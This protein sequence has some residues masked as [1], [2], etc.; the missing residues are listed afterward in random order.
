MRRY[1]INKTSALG[2]IAQSLCVAQYLKAKMGPCT[3]DWI[4][5]EPGAKLVARHP[6]VDSVLTISTRRW[7]STL[8]RSATFREFKEALR[9]LR[10]HRYDAIFD[11]QGNFKSGMINLLARAKVKVGFSFAQVR[12]S[13]NAL[14][15]NQRHCCEIL[16]IPLR[17]L[18]LVRAHFGDVETFTPRPIYLAVDS[19]EKEL[20]HTWALDASAHEQFR[21]ILICPFSAWPSKQIDK[22]ELGALV[23]ILSMRFK[24]SIWVASGS[25]SEWGL[26]RHIAEL[27]SGK[28]RA[29]PRLQLP[30]FQ[31]LMRQCSCLIGLDSLALHLAASADVPTFGI[32]GPTHPRGYAPSFSTYGAKFSTHFWKACTRYP[33]GQLR[34]RS[35][36]KCHGS[37]LPTLRRGEGLAA[38][39]D[40]IETVNDARVVEPCSRNSISSGG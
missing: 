5:E 19:E 11:L 16:P 2:D 34:C 23:E 26:A 39:C 7:R 13:L 8:W 9:H 10:L 18:Q 15:T 36:R 14:T 25:D 38:L 29:L 3:V 1:L 33:Q 40:F 22:Q 6:D 28:C 24:N 30:V 37:C 35:M 31:Y 27:S 12:E 20:V 17:Y 32:F 4:A 21:P